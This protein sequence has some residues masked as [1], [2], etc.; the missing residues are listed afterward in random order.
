MANTSGL[1]I[2]RQEHGVQAAGSLC[3]SI[4]YIFDLSKCKPFKGRTLS[5]RVKAS[6]A[7]AVLP[8]L[9]HHCLNMNV[10]IQ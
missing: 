7:E 2:S 9:D 10:K 1:R 8:A 5:E 6:Q 3:K 4:C